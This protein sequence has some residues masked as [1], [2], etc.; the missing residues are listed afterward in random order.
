MVVVYYKFGL[1]VGSVGY[2]YFSV[3]LCIV[4][5]VVRY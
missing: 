2:Y 5:S 1:G 3:Y 4:I